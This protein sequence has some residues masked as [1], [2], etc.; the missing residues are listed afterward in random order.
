M[1]L[2]SRT[3]FGAAGA[4]L[5]TTVAVA[6][7]RSTPAEPTPTP[8]RF[9]LE[10]RKPWTGSRVVG[11]PDPLPPY[12]VER[13]FPKL[14]FNN[15]LHLTN[16]PGTERLF[17]CEQYGKI[18]SFP[19][20]PA[21]AQADLFLDVKQV[22]GAKPGGPSKGLAHV[23][24]L[25]FHPRFAENRYCYVSYV[26]E[27]KDGKPLADSEHVSRFTVSTAD[28]P[29]CDPASEVVLLTWTT[30]PGG[31]NG[32]CLCFGPDGCLY[33]SMGDAAAPNP[34][35]PENTGQDISDLRSSIM[36]IDVD[37]PDPG[38]TY[39][40]PKDNP[41]VSLPGA[42]PEVWAYGF[43]NPW[44]MSFDRATGDLWVGDVGWEL[45][46]MVYRVRKGGNYGWSITEGPQPIK[47]EGKRGPT[48][49]L[50]PALALPHSE[51]AS[52]T[53]GF[54]YRGKK[55][56][57]LVG[58]YVF[59]DWMTRKV[60]ATRFSA[61]D[62]IVSHQEIAQGPH[63]IVA[64]GEDNQ[65][66]LYYVDYA[67]AGGLYALVPNEAAAKPR[68]PFPAKLS[69]TG[70]FES[71]KDYRPAPGVLPFSVNAEQWVDYATSERL[72]GLPGSSSIKVFDQAKPLPGTA[73]FSS[74]TFFPEGAVL[75]RTFALE[76]E[77]GHPAT[78][79]RL[80][81]QL[82]H[83]DGDDWRGYSYRWND[84]Q[85]DAALVPA[86]GEDRV[87]E[88]RD[89]AAPGGHRK[90]TWHYPS[91]AECR[92]CHNGWAG[93]LLAFTE[94]QLRREQ[95]YGG[96]RADQWATLKHVGVFV[97]GEPN[98]PAAKSAKP[99]APLTD[100]SDAHQDLDRRARSYLHANCAHCHS[101]GAGGSV[102]MSLR[103]DQPLA[104]T[105][106]LDVRP[107]QGTF[108][109]PEARI[110][111]PGDP[112]HSTLYYRMAKTGRGRMPHIGSEVVD[113]A[114]L[115]LIHDWIRHLP[116]AKTVA[117][118]RTDLEKLSGANGATSQAER[119]A[120]TDRLL[121]EPAAALGLLHALDA[122]QVPEPVR[123]QVIA[124]AM[125]KEA[126]VRDLFERFV[127]DDQKVQRLGNTIVPETILTRAG[128]P[129][130]G[131]E[132]FKSPG[133]QC[134]NCH[135]VAGVGGEV[136]PDLSEIG[137]KYS[138]RQLLESI[139]DPSKDIDPKFA[140][141]LAETD[142]GRTFLG[143]LVSK[144]AKEVVLRDTQGQVIRLSTAKVTALE[145]SKKS[146]M[147]EGLLRELTIQQAADLIAYLESLK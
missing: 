102:D 6:L 89:P 124:V 136:G 65:G 135:K 120:A 78:R 10:A 101:F 106:A 97:P 85:T 41:F 92:Q 73:F 127:P 96:V 146:L 21:I 38:K 140:S 141:Y 32:G 116:A 40:V 63:K 12:R 25:T 109:I 49:I 83:F 51:A 30:Y 34:P 82:F 56:P 118:D 88:V 107:M 93:T 48:P 15:P 121:A 36:R 2:P 71:V 11:T 117:E 131:K 57:S 16:A 133:L 147:P 5:L 7:S 26:L 31:H 50:P 61:D 110:L 52:V 19:N 144:D 130:R 72:L 143:L 46:E 100:P 125:T 87:L 76:L 122:R 108:G 17:V 3:H 1:T 14:T 138:R 129:A 18:F 75:T 54:V 29:R 90:Q 81:T 111:T 58:A 59:G 104:Q 112:F 99:E 53:G 44:K 13:A 22:P 62:K 113:E 33:A 20:D 9:G 42:R 123:A 139:L 55:Y 91:R 23:Y 74:K 27:P 4:A 69:E 145:A 94:P 66:E 95:D 105:K 142:D 86:S 47:P 119:A 132:V 39:G 103:Y 77:R 35:D 28:P 80:E 137:K 8:P 24:G 64:F 126:P 45:W 114:G 68:Q 84:E 67:D 98:K 60:W 134:A 70:L 79:K 43:R 128:D 37:H 115:T